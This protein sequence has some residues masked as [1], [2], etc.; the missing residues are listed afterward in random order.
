MRT[1]QFFAMLRDAE[2]RGAITRQQLLTIRGQYLH[3]QASDAIRGADRL[4]AAANAQLG[5]GSK[6]FRFTLR[7]TD[8][9]RERLERNA[10]AAGVTRSEYLREL[11][12]QAPVTT[13]PKK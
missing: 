2:Q 10:E 3:G 1:K 9:Q 12:V 7:M 4:I 13:P 8:G 11:L 5:A 6:F